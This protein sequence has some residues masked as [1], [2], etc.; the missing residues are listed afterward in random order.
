MIFITLAKQKTVPVKFLY[1]EIRIL[2]LL[3]YEVYISSKI[4]MVFC[5]ERENY[6]YEIYME[7]NSGNESDN[8][9]KN[10]KTR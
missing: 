8:I 1:Y 2:Y 7:V 3:S 5:R 9:K 4:S 10:W 6:V